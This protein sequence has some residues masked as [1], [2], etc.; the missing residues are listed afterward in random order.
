MRKSY[1]YWALLIVSSLLSIAAMAQQSVT[2]SGNVKNSKTKDVI[3]AV[4]VMI[5][6]T[7][8]GTFTD[9][10]GNFKLSTTQKLPFTLVISSVGF[11]Q[12]EVSV[13][14]ANKVI[15]VDFVPS[16]ALGEDVVVSASRVPERILESPVS[17]ERLSSQAIRSA[18]APTYY[19]AIANLKGVDMTVSSLT[20]K[21]VSTRGFNG[22][23]SLRFNQYID[24]MDNQAPGLNFAVGNIIG[25]TELDVDNIELLPGASS[26]LYGAGGMNGTM[27]ITSKNPFKNQGLSWQVKQGIM[28]TDKRQR[29][30]SPYFDWNFRWGKKVSEKFA[31]KVT[32]QFIQARDWQAQDYRNYDRFGSKTIAGDRSNPSYDGVNIYGDEINANMTTVAQAMVTAN[33]LPAAALALIPSNQVVSRTGYLERD[34]V[35]YN[36]YNV[37]LTGGAFYKITENIEASFQAYWGIGTTVYTGS[38]RYSLKDV[39][40][41]QYQFNVKGKDFNVRLYTTQENAGESYNATVLSQLMNESWKPSTTWFPQYVGAFVAARTGGASVDAAHGIARGNADIGR[42]MPGS[43][44]F[45]SAYN[46]LR[47]RPIPQGGLFLDKSDLYVAEGT[48]NFSR[49]L[50]NVIDVQVGAMVRQFSLN[51]QGTLFDDANGRIKI[52][53]VGGFVQLQKKLFNDVLKLTASGR[54]DKNENFQGRF[55]PR[56]SAVVK[57]AEDNNFRA[58]YQ[59]GFRIPST[60]NQF[61]DLNAG[62][63]RLVGGLPWAS[64]KYN[65]TGN[66]IYTQNNVTQ[67]GGA[68]QAALIANSGNIP[69]A[70]GATAGILQPYKVPEFKPE[71]VKSYEVGYK[72][73]IGKKFL[74]DAY[75]YISNYENFI[76]TQIVI[77][78]RQPL[79]PGVPA[80][81]ALLSGNT[82]QVYSMPVTTTTAVDAQGFGIGFEYLLPKSFVLSGNYASDKLKNVPAGLVT[83][84]N[85]PENRYNIGFRNDNIAKRYGFN[86][87]YRWQDDVNYEGTF[88]SGTTPAY[89]TL[90]AQ[91]SMK[92][93]EKRSILKI[94]GS[95]IMNKYFYNAF[96]NP[97]VGG[98][99]Y[100]SFA[101]NVF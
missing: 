4:S 89:G 50:D 94:G 6:G 81:L 23:G 96:G 83:F 71:S 67:F 31:F 64:A 66:P 27:L 32:G 33:V 48:Y 22:S 74:I 92:F 46:T 28:H 100:V 47:A 55:T 62:S 24:G 87:L 77:Q 41:G 19:E 18:A 37:K 73:I 40:L 13:S 60:Q 52:N 10:K 78:A 91:I 85:A 86:V 59:T 49:L 21:T 88:V 8:T 42:L 30:T 84:F 95:N 17:I 63:A 43:A 76:G 11:T 15:A 101:Y 53:E 35:D 39:K 51:S 69:A 99:Y 57:V 5:K 14:D 56:V 72:G 26:A 29:N 2:I 44:G 34:V 93:P 68:F 58:S 79:P 61:I 12:Q 98:M 38:D 9:D 80:P 90:D 20:F 7:N 54:Y 97:E 70:L 36:T 45:T 65:F 25:I 82:R 75:Y 3:S 1:S 16:I